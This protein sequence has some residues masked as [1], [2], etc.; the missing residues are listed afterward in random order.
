MTTDTKYTFPGLLLKV[1]EGPYI[2]EINW[3]YTEKKKKKKKKKARGRQ[4]P[5][6]TITEAESVYDHALQANTP[7]QDES[8]L[9][10]QEQTTRGISLFVNIEQC[11]R[12]LIKMMPSPD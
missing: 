5:T 12:V 2:N 3:F 10:C 8:V 6:G 9:H 11:S 4:H 1:Y 7:A